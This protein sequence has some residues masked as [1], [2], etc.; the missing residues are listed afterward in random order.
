MS[1]S[2]GQQKLYKSNTVCKAKSI[3]F[4]ISVAEGR[5]L[6]DQSAARG[7]QAM[8]FCSLWTVCVF[9]FLSVMQP[10]AYGST[11]QHSK[12]SKGSQQNG[13]QHGRTRT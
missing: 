5:D 4:Q 12:A 13:H 2:L 10:K 11:A 7:S 9:G 6:Q 1:C 8:D 3:A